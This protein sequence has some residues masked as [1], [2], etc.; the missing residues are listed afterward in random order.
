MVLAL[1]GSAVG[2]IGTFALT[3]VVA[4]QLYGIQST[5]PLTFAGVTALL[6]GITLLACYLPARR[7][8]QVDPMTAL[9][10]E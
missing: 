8:A 4:S 2:L 10:H 7:A 1:L 9:R 3:G 6:F 5:D